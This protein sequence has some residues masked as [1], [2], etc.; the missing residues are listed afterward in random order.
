MSD[1]TYVWLVAWDDRFVKPQRVEV[2]EVTRLP[3]VADADLEQHL[4]GVEIPGQARELTRVGGVAW[5]LLLKVTGERTQ[6]TGFG[7]A[8][9]GVAAPLG[10]VAVSTGLNADVV[11]SSLEEL[12]ENWPESE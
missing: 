12:P 10:T 9:E 3:D 8:Q 5:Q 11:W 1:A 2:R 7:A 4:I 6:A